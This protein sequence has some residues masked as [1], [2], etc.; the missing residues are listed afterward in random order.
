MLEQLSKK[1]SLNFF[2]VQNNKRTL[3]KQLRKRSSMNCNVEENQKK[4]KL[5]VHEIK[6]VVERLLILGQNQQ[7]YSPRGTSSHR[8]LGTS[9]GAAYH[10]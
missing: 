6:K 4:T 8:H 7:A 5:Q 2:K 10:L 3:W 9:Q 1:K